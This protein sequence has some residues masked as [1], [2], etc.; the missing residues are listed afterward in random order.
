MFTEQ[1]T[2]GSKKA[3]WKIPVADTLRSEQGMLWRPLLAQAAWA[4]LVPRESREREGGREPGDGEP[5]L[6]V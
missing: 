6:E 5:A 1:T 4:Q 3:L 2:G